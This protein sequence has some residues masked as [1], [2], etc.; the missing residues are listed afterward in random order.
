M[1]GLENTAKRNNL[2]LQCLK[3]LSLHRL[4]DVGMNLFNGFSESSGYPEIRMP[5]FAKDT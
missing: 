3:W 1:D 4:V 2:C 5:M